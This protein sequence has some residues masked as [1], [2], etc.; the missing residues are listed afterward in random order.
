MGKD[1][2]KL[3][4]DEKK[5][6]IKLLFAGTIITFI[7]GIKA[8]NDTKL[9]NGYEL[10]K[11]E[12]S[13]GVYDQKLIA[14]VEDEK[15][16]LTVTVDTRKLS[17][18]EAEEALLKAK[19]QLPELLRGE[20]ETLS[21]VITDLNFAETVPDSTVEVTWVETAS[22]YFEEDGK[23]RDDFEIREPVEQN[24]SAILSC[25]GY[26][27]DFETVVTIYPREKTM[28]EILLKQIQ[29]ENGTFENPVLVLPK[30]YEGSR[31][32]WKKPLD[33]TFLYFFALTVGAVLFLKLGRKRDEKEAGRERIEELE[34]DYAQ[35][36]SKFAML[37]SA[38][39]SVRNAWE[40]IVFL[41]R[42]KQDVDRA[43]Y[44]ELQ[45]GLKEMQK[46]ISELAVYENV[47]FRIGEIHYKKLM[48]L[49]ISHKK[50]G[51]VNLL[52]TMN[53]EM[54]QAWEEQKRKTRQQGEK[55]G[56]KLLIPMMGMLG[57]VFIMIL[58]PAFLSFQL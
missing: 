14:S 55:T 26:T 54:L 10:L 41:Y 20:N 50:R 48:L 44:R 51:S 19:K 42:R 2:L 45:W 7:L 46:G 11:N 13:E 34:K 58:V 32:S 22:E 17:E 8:W 4:I 35:I 39:L 47:A 30:E 27:K 18:K 38:G 25:Q 52:E 15:I 36:V 3:N 5:L 1:F 40:R 29:K 9:E 24:L 33:L 23:L 12:E 28:R 53:E 57:V 56:T 16:P 31:I 43:V 21:K 6:Y 37:L 49:F